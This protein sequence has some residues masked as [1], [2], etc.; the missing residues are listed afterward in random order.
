MKKSKLSAAMPWVIG[1]VGL[2]SSVSASASSYAVSTDS[3]TNFSIT[4][5]PS[6]AF[7]GFTF[8]G[9]FSLSLGALLGIEAH[10]SMQDAAPACLGSYCSSFN[11]SFSSHGVSPSPG[12]VYSDAKIY[13]TNVLGGTGAA[14]TIDEV[15]VYDGAAGS[16]STNAM[17]AAFSLASA[18]AVNFSFNALPFM[19]TQ[20]LSGGTGANSAIGM[21]ITIKKS[22][23]TVFQWTPNG[24]SGGI[25]N[26]TEVY[27]PF[28]LNYS[29]GSNLVYN[30]GSG[31]FGASTNLLSGNYTL[32]IAMANAVTATS[33][34]V[35]PV[36]AA[37][38][39]FG[40]GAAALAVLAKRRKRTQA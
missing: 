14:S 17:H 29:I 1:A 19:S 11:N 13:S 4:G 8:S 37:L 18:S 31:L 21:G 16:T 40:S 12:Y 20:L 10:L 25:F 2:F 35:V 22:G 38:P 7:G 32:D 9:D 23:T 15:T 24:T 3:I 28:N 33:T 27:D 5:I 30:P 34:T 39:L 36:P 26:G 6:S